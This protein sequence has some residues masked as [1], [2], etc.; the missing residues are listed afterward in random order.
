MKL[1]AFCVGNEPSNEY[2]LRFTFLYENSYHTNERPG[3]ET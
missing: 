3:G 2:L 1:C